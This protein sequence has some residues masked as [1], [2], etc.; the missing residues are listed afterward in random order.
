MT[1]STVW[2]G[3]R[4][5][6]GVFVGLLVSLGLGAA[7]WADPTRPR[8]SDRHATMVV[9]RLLVRDHLS[10]RK[11]DDEISQGF[12]KNFLKSLDPW[13]LYFSQSDVD[14][15]MKRRHDLD[16]M[17]R[18]GDVDF[19]YE[20]FKTFLERVDERVKLADELLAID[21]DFSLDE[22]MVTDRDLARYARTPAEARERWRKRIKYELLLLKV[23]GME[24]KQAAEKLTRRYRS[25][26]RR[27]HQTDGAEVLEM[28]LTSL[29][30]AFDPHSRFMSP[31]ALE[32]HRIAM[33]QELEG[34]GAALQSVD[35]QIVVKKIIPG[36]A[37][38]RDGRLKAE[39]KIVGVGQGRDGRITSVVDLK[40][41]EVV[42][43]IRGKRG[44]VVRLEVVSAGRA[45]SRILDIPRGMVALTDT[46]ARGAIFRHG[47]KSD[48]QP[49]QIGMVN[50]PAFYTDLA[51]A[52]QG[53]KDFKSSTRDVR[54]ILD[55][56]RAQ[57]VDAV[58]LDL[59]RDSG[60]ATTEL[61]E[62]HE[63][64]RLTGL[65]LSEGPIVQVKRADGRVR[66]YHDVDAATAWKE[67]LVVLTSKFTPG[68]GE[69][70]AAA[71][72]DHRRGLIVG[73]RATR[74]RGTGQELVDLGQ[75]LFRVP[76]APKLGAL[77]I[78]TRQFYR[79]GG[80]SIQ[81]RGVL[82][83]VELPSLTTHLDV[84]EADLD[85]SLAPDRV[86][87]LEFKKL[88][89]VNQAIC[90]RLK[91]L[92]SQR[93]TNSEDFQSVLGNI[94]RYK[95]QRKR[96]RVTLNEES[97]A[98]QRTE[99]GVDGTGNVKIRMTEEIDDPNQPAVKRDYYL[100]EVLAITADYLRLGKAAAEN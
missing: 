73:D 55:D 74:G 80:D 57:S 51:A 79:P 13:K 23:D 50:L 87:P 1:R 70:L 31:A 53:V 83:D 86:E 92:S 3:R 95:E 85:Y 90:D 27:M 15:F 61:V 89:H 4:R 25:F 24:A 93:C 5:S 9:A 52:R 44:T 32:N 100:D 63:A 60:D 29:A 62:P 81:R 33:R 91:E 77:K 69:I 6:L 35:G 16:E 71:I 84:G 58:V 46:D 2:V 75:K 19:A 76:N 99:M 78:T 38:D 68:G 18:K 98:K 17:A 41:S 21:H 54:K 72:Q 94:S 45:Q 42:K 36:A 7:A 47:R 28:Y 30:A 43:M 97:F 59:R 48:G 12:L 82:A 14:A 11:L 88:D 20:V 8:A 67:P 66:P 10:G 64:I 37:A 49:Y 40:L 22:E 39:D 65:F 56:F 96:Q 34:I 26:A